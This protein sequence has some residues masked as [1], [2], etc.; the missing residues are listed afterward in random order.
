MF[1]L[2]SFDILCVLTT[3]IQY[4][5]VYQLFLDLY[6]TYTKFYKFFLVKKTYDR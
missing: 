6:I 3:W 1:F 4:D 2:F 5:F